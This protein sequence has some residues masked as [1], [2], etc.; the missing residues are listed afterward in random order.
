MSFVV[1]SVVAHFSKIAHLISF[2]FSKAWSA[3]DYAKKFMMIGQA[4][5]S[6][7]WSK[8]AD[9]PKLFPEFKELLS[10]SSFLSKGKPCVLTEHPPLL[11]ATS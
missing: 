9:N 5:I 7:D 1:D 8:I 3:S 4:Q 6:G 2:A 11:A 10:N